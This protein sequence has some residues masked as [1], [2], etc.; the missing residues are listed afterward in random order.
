MVSVAEKLLEESKQNM[1]HWQAVLPVIRGDQVTVLFYML[2]ILHSL[3]IGN[4]VNK[5]VFV[6]E[7]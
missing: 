5:L 1:V 3:K 4:K 6:P 7:K 2:K